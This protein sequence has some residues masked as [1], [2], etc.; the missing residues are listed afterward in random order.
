MNRSH[1]ECIIWNENALFGL[2][3]DLVAYRFGYGLPHELR[4]I[5]VEDVRASL[6]RMR[7]VPSLTLA[8]MACGT[9]ARCEVC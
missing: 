7:S 4:N 6:T 9:D 3:L 8:M 1:P 5:G 2:L